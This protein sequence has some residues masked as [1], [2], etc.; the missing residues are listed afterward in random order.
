MG[1][2]SSVK[3]PHAFML[4]LSFRTI[5]GEH[6]RQGVVIKAGETIPRVAHMLR[7]LADN[8]EWNAKEG[9]KGIQDDRSEC[10]Q[11]REVEIGEEGI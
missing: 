7:Q 2:P 1:H 3:Y 4:G 8:I 11:E 6:W 5:E 9:I 10:E